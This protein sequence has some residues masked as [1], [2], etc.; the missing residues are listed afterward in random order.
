MASAS[1]ASGPGPRGFA[2]R[3]SEGE[4]DRG[5]P[6]ARFRCRST[7]DAQRRAG[8]TVPELGRRFR[9][10][11]GPDARA[12]AGSPVRTFTIGF[13]DGEKL[14]RDRTTRARWP[15]RFGADHD[16]MIVGAGR[17]PALLRPLPAGTSRS[18]SATRP[19]PRSTSSARSRAARSRSPS[20]A[21]APTSRGRATTATSASSCRS[22]YSRLPDGAHRRPDPPA[23]RAIRAQRA[24]ATWRRRAVGAGSPRREW[25]RSTRS[26]ART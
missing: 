1:S 22:Y 13:E 23:G 2:A 3:R 5:V 17:L 6:G 26:S 16:E 12:C 19:R 25:S 20:P 4:L 18:R 24:P 9:R 8:R 10:A 11:A 14:Q 15:H 7:P 21:R